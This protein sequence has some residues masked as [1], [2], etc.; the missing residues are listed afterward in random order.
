MRAETTNAKGQPVPYQVWS[1][2]FS[3]DGRH[4][5][6]GSGFDPYGKARNLIQVWNVDTRTPDGEP[7]QGP[8][9]RGLRG[10]F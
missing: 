7:M 9:G 6:T 3:P 8:S 2:A 4:M 1:V 5:V 10:G